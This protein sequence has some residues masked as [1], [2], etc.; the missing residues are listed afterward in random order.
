[1]CTN[2]LNDLEMEPEPSAHTQ[3]LFSGAVVAEEREREK[4]NGK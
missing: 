3:G 1:M 4:E 2:D